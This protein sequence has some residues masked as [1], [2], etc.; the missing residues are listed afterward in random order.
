MPFSI[1]PY[2]R[3]PVQRSITYNA[4]PFLTLPLAYRVGFESHKWVLRPDRHRG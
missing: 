4:G 3:F 1:C 2:R